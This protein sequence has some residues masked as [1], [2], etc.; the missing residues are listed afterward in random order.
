MVTQQD[1]NFSERT[2]WFGAARYEEDRF[3]GFDYQATLSTGLGRKFIDTARTTF[4]GT[5]GGGY[6]IFETLDAF[7]E[8]TGLLLEEGKREGEA[9]FRGTLDFQHALTE[10]TKLIDKFIIESGADNTYVQNDL[11]LQVKM[12]QV[13][14][15]AVGYGVR[16]NSN[17]P[18]GFEN[19][20]TLT[21]VNL[22]YELK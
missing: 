14:A 7:D 21:T 13:L 6:K 16:Y 20:D 1:Y 2:F 4:I 5:T 8:E 15:L 18:A 19:T 12:T 22:V 17:P 10:S 9:V 11:S 3:S